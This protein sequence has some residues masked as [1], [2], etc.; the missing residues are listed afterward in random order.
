MP[1][2][3]PSLCL[4]SPRFSD[5]RLQELAKTQGALIAWHEFLAKDAKGKALAKDALESRATRGVAQ[6]DF[7]QTLLSV[8]LAEH[9]GYFGEMVWILMMLEQWLAAKAPHTKF[10]N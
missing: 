7:V 6:A 3:E 8:K 5:S 10:G 1:A 9:P 4:G 2:N